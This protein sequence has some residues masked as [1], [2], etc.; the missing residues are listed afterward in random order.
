MNATSTD[1]IST[2]YQR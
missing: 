2:F 1:Q